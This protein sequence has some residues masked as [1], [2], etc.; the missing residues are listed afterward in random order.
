M[1]WITGIFPAYVKAVSL[2]SRFFTGLQRPKAE[3]EEVDQEQQQALQSHDFRTLDGRA[4]FAGNL[5]RSIGVLVGLTGTAIVLME[6]LADELRGFLLA[7]SGWI[8]LGLFALMLGLLFYSYRR[9]LRKDW[10]DS[11][12]MAEKYRYAALAEAALTDDA[13][14]MRALA[15]ATVREQVAYNDE[16]AKLYHGIK[17]FSD[18]AA[19]AVFGVFLG[20]LLLQQLSAFRGAALF[21]QALPAVMG[22]IQGINGFLRIGNLATD[23]E[24]MAAKLRELGQELAQSRTLDELKSASRKIYLVL[25]TRDTKWVTYAKTLTLR[26]N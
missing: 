5:Y 25:T 23:H 15:E 12:A 2:P 14:A 20:I 9:K 22:G 3:V 11:R 24:D 21:T 17:N 26:P 18:K 1:K 13:D 7:H 6:L 10:I 8:K 4:T 19:I 16:K